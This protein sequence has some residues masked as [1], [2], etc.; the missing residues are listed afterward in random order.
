MTMG[1]SLQIIIIFQLL[2]TCF[3]MNKSVNSK[4]LG[5]IVFPK[6]SRVQISLLDMW[7]TFLSV[8]AF[9]QGLVRQLTQ[10]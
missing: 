8:F 6:A 7:F 4:N 3:D 1:K 2:N 5:I 10:Q 9:A